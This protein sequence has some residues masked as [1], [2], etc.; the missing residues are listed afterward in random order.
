[1]YGS[2]KPQFPIHVI[3]GFVLKPSA[4][5]TVVDLLESLLLLSC[6]VPLEPYINIC[7]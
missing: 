3:V 6:L 2:V 5:L 1:M 7:A 4:S